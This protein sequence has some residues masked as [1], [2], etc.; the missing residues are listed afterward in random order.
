M[1]EET[2]P[3]KLITEEEFLELLD[4]HGLRSEKVI[5]ACRRVFVHGESR[6]GAAIACGV[7]YATLYRTVRR[8][9]G[10]CPAC[11]QALPQGQALQPAGLRQRPEPLRDA[12]HHLNGLPQALRGHQLPEGPERRGSSCPA[13]IPRAGSKRA[14]LRLH[15]MVTN[16]AWPGA[17]VS[18]K[19][20]PSQPKR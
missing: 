9:Q 11:G 1:R 14:P 19:K 10:L 12:Q 17:G 20:E 7:N 13:R 6:R 18:P 8:L 4:S 2:N 3:V 15:G 16:R 5:E